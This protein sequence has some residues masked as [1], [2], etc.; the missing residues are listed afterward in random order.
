MLRATLITLTILGATTAQAQDTTTAEALALEY[1]AAAIRFDEGAAENLMTPALRDLI[2]QARAANDAFL[3][4]YPGDKPPLGDGLPLTGYQDATE[5]CVP[6]SV[7]E[8]S[9]VLIY[10]PASSPS[11]IWRDQIEFEAQADGTLAV[12]DILYAPDLTQRFSAVMT[13]I[14]T[15]TY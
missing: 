9:A 12:S 14:A 11:D 4:K 2:A 15:A 10:A 13:G 8:T 3:K 5:S 1:C 7:T 6:E